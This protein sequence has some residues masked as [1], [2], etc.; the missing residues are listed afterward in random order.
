MGIIRQQAFRSSLGIIAGTLAGAINTI[1]V[2]PAAFALFPEGWGLLKVL[3]AYATLFAQFCSFGSSAIF[4]RFSPKWP[5]L[6]PQLNAF[7]LLLPTLALIALAL[8]FALTGDA[9]LAQFNPNDA[10]LLQN[11]WALLFYLSAALTYTLA[12]SGF[13]GAMLKTAL[14]QILNEL[15]L[16]LLYLALAIAY[17]FAWIDFEA[18]VL[19]YAATYGLVL[20]LLLLY[21]L[22]AGLRLA[23]PAQLPHKGEVLRFGL[24]AILD[25]GASILVSNLDII[26]ISLY[27]SLNEVAS[28]TLAFYIGSV[29]LIPQKSLQMIAHGVVA[30]AIEEN[31]R[32][33]IEAVYVK[34]SLNQFILGSLLFLGIWINVREIFALL[35]P[36][37]AGGEWVV[38]FIGLSKMFYLLSGIN[39][40]MIV[41]S[42]YYR[43]NFVLNL[44]LVLLTLATNAW[45][46]PRYGLNGAA[47]ATAI[48]FLLYNAAK[49]IYVHRVFGVQPFRRPLLLALL[50]FTLFSLG[51]YYLQLPWPPFW[52][53]VLKG[54]AVTALYALLLHALGISEDL[55]AL[56]RSMF[57]RMFSR[58][59]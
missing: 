8:V 46:I 13:L 56:T 14:Y 48:S 27:L 34:S 21:S 16:K 4:V 38:L 26:M 59:D 10:A 49:T 20:L 23:S 6:T 53:I 54:T 52:S 22:S 1:V 42:R 36:Q 37:F 50:F 58:K 39:A 25:R 5:R 17:L 7:A 45:L 31:N 47:L 32:A 12:L 19:L 9:L 29:V 41:F 40:G 15:V 11:R 43:A 30:R 44:V 3:V 33:Q 55:S 2:L 51:G 28:Y 24:Y 35:P 57:K 18:L